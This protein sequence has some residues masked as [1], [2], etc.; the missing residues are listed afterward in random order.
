MF[1]CGVPQ[2]VGRL[3]YPEKGEQEQHDGDAALHEQKIVLSEKAL[4]EKPPLDEP[5]PW[6]VIPPLLLQAV[7]ITNN[8]GPIMG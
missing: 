5:G 3:A 4:H 7:V 2:G 6:T 1:G 8:D